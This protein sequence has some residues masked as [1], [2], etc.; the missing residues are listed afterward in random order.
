M[1]ELSEYPRL[2]WHL[3]VL[4][5]M[6]LCWVLTI[7][8]FMKLSFIIQRDFYNNYLSSCSTELLQILSEITVPFCKTTFI[9]FF[10]A[11]MMGI[12]VLLLGY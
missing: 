1:L 5:E 2:N 9:H 3:V 11:A 7:T 6:V 10:A 12:I 8:A 4:N